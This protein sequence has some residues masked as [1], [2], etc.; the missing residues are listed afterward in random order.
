MLPG[1]WVTMHLLP[2][3]WLEIACIHR[4]CLTKRD[5]KVVLVYRCGILCY[6]GLPIRA[7]LRALM[8]KMYVRFVASHQIV[9][10]GRRAL[11]TCRISHM[12]VPVATPGMYHFGYA[13]RNHVD[14]GNNLFE[15][16]MFSKRAVHTK[17]GLTA[18][19]TFTV[20]RAAEIYA[21]T[22]S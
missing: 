17:D 19:T 16:A 7:Q 2:N 1:Y 15:S 9:R 3:V 13:V 12:P 22:T 10:L 18:F 20:L 4:P 11:S 5:A 6:I 14:Q 8:A 21:F